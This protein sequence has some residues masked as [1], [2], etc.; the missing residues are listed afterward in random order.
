M[1]VL[2]VLILAC[3]TGFAVAG[4]TAVC[5]PFVDR[6]ETCKEAV[7]ETCNTALKAKMLEQI[8]ASPAGF[9]DEMRKGLDQKVLGFCNGFISQTTGDQAL[10]MCTEKMGGTDPGI[11]DQVKDMQTCLAKETCREYAECA[12]KFN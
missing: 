1:I 6:N 12:V 10:G 3:A 8:A 7:L 4:D 2:F 11:A 5:K 9:Q